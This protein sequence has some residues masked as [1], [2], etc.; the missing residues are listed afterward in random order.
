MYLKRK[1]DDE[2]AAK[3]SKLKLPHVYFIE[4][5]HRVYLGGNYFSNV[6]GFTDID[7]KGQEGIEYAKN[8]QLM[9]IGGLKKVR[10]DNLGRSIETIELIKK[11]VPGK[12]IYLS[13]DKKVQLIAYNILKEYVKKDKAESASLVLIKNKT[14]EIIS[15]VNYPSFNPDLRHEMSGVKIKNRVATEIFEPG[16]TIKPFLIL[17]ALDSNTFS[18]KDLIDTTPGIIKIGEEHIV[19]RIRQ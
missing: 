19:I 1:I 11:P 9:S 8:D 17:S 4:E 12:N 2:I 3:I 18:Q 13:L 5:F 6:I 10:K 14:G 16:S 7:D 15:M